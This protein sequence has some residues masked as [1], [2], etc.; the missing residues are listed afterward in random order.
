M[1]GQ[2]VERCQPKPATK[3]A[4]YD[5]LASSPSVTGAKG[6]THPTQACQEGQKL[7]LTYEDKERLLV[8]VREAV[9]G[10]C[11]DARAEEYARKT[12]ELVDELVLNAVFNANPRLR[13]ARRGQP[14][15]LPPEEG[16]LVRWRRTEGSFAVS[17]RDPFGSLRYPTLLSHLDA[18]LPREELSARQ[19]AG[20]GLRMAFDRSHAF[21]VDVSNGSSTEIIAFLRLERSFREFDRRLRSL[22]FF[23]GVE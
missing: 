10:G 18:S 1:R 21:V 6:H 11:I 19:S 23:G 14:F 3:P 8:Q 22:H 20:L 15:V 5:W 9:H 7:I 13:T 17:V 4:P 12:V 16:V 2:H